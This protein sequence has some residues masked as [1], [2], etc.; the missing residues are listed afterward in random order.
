M[1]PNSSSTNT[2]PKLET[3]KL[4]CKDKTQPITTIISQSMSKLNR[5]GQANSNS[6]GERELRPRIEMKVE[7]NR[8]LGPFCAYIEIYK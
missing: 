1:I 6:E 8:D 3:A 7:R 4:N 5:L 2:C